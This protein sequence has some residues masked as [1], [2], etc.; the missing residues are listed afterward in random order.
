MKSSYEFCN[1]KQT[2]TSILVFF[3]FTSFSQ[4]AITDKATIQPP[5]NQQYKGAIVVAY[6][7]PFRLRGI[8][9]DFDFESSLSL[10]SNLLFVFGRRNHAESCVDTPFG[11][12]LTGVNLNDKNS[13]VTEARKAS[14][15]TLST[16]VLLKPTKFANLGIFIGWNNLGSHDKEVNW[17]YNKKTWL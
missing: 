1:M 3:A 12:G 14:A 16:G 13:D 17:N 4:E 8:G 6:T 2:T 11:I 9:D 15:F 5:P 10:Q 7:I